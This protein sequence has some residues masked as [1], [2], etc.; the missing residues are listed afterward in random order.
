[1]LF[2]LISI[3]FLDIKFENIVIN[4]FQV[5]KKKCASCHTVDKGGDTKAGP[6]LYGLFG[7]RAGQASVL[8]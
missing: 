7:R 3:R 1:M 4:F 6:N 8:I 5:F 2:Q